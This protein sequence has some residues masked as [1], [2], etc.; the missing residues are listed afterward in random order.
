MRLLSFA[1]AR[2][3]SQGSDSV[4]TIFEQFVRCS[5]ASK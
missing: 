2:L 1:I 4:R 5:H 3:K